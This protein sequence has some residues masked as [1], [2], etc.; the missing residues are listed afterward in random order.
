MG[1]LFVVG[2]M[3]V[4]S[5]WHRVKWRNLR[6]LLCESTTSCRD[7]SPRIL[8]NKDLENMDWARIFD[9]WKSTGNR[10]ALSLDLDD[11]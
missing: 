9:T 11:D 6:L 5:K 2:P 3:R 1:S 8:S 10:R 7:W 4:M